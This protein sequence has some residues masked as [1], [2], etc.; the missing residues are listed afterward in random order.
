MKIDKCIKRQNLYK[1]HLK[2][3]L[4]QSDIARKYGLSRQRVSQ[5]INKIYTGDARP[6]NPFWDNKPKWLQ[7]GRDRVREL[8]RCRDN[9]TCQ[10][11]FKEWKE[12]NRRFDIHHLGG[13][14]GKKS[15]KYDSLK[16]KDD[17]I[18]LCHRC[19]FNHP[20]HSQKLKVV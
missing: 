8:I 10:S 3:G 20:E 9:Y 15:R 2:E 18:T 5:I 1:K 7:K 14:C 4:T 17:L 13:M 16:N 12:G 6:P 19:H 11:C